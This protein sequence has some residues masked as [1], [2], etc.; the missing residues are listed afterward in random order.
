MK[1]KE[2]CVRTLELIPWVTKV[3]VDIFLKKPLGST[4]A[5]G[6]SLRNVEHVIAVSSCKVPSYVTLEKKLQKNLHF[7]YVKFTWRQCDSSQIT[8]GDIYDET[9]MTFNIMNSFL[10]Q[11]SIFSLYFI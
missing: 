11:H 1:I 5:M 4:A 9:V 3:E 2:E 6:S 7:L 8:F 10:F